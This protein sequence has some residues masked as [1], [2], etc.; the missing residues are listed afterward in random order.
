MGRHLAD[1][2]L[3][4]E[5]KI[6]ELGKDGTYIAVHFSKATQNKLRDLA[7]ALS[8]PKGTRVE[9]NKMHCTIVYSRKP[10][11]DFTIHGKMKEPWIGTPTKLEIFPS[12]SGSRALVLRFDCPEM[13]ER[14]E[15]FNKEYGAQYDYD[16]YKIHATL[17]YDVGEDWQ[18]PK[19]FDIKKH[20]DKLEIAEEYY[21]PLNLDWAKG[22]S[23]DKDDDK[24]EGDK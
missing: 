24:K 7:E 13:K 15:Y 9:R 18:I 4:K 22:A 23:D 16:E 14:H 5:T 17:C 12:Q 3:E 10:F 19:D 21:E 1:I 8:I 6:T 2:L 20:I 11:K